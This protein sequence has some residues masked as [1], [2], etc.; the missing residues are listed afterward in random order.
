MRKV[1]TTLI[2]QIKV[3]DIPYENVD[4][5]AAWYDVYWIRTFKTVD[6]AIAFAEAEIAAGK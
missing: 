2:F 4:P 1:S 6:E 5:N 3:A